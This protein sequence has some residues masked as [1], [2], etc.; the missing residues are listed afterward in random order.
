MIRTA[1][2]AVEVKDVTRALARARSITRSVG[3]VVESETTD[4]LDDMYETSTVVLRVPEG[5]YDVVLHELA[6]TGK[7]LS[8]SAKAKDVTEQVVDVRS[9]IATQRASVDRLR[10]L[11]DRAEDITDVVALEGQLNDRQADLEALLARQKSLADRTAMATVTLDLTERAAEKKE[12]ETG[13]GFLDALGGG[14][15]AF[16]SVLRWIVVVVAAILPFVVALAVLYGLWLLLGARLFG[17]RRRT[18]VTGPATR[19]ATEPATEPTTGPATEPAT[20][21]ATDTTPGSPPSSTPDVAT[22]PGTDPARETSASP[23]LVTRDERDRS[24]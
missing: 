3:G 7:L 16:V 22:D 20:G 4:R 2:L 6:G 18:A 11:M 5:E 12:E 19:T 1:T 14:W 23:G 10:T 9:R 13:P 15:D 21:P 17:L 8:R 24:A